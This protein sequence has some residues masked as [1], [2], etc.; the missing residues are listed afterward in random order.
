MNAV[1]RQRLSGR[2]YKHGSRGAPLPWA[3]YQQFLAGLGVGLAVALVVYLSDFRQQPAVEE[4]PAPRP[5]AGAASAAES[6]ADPSAGQYDFCDM[7]PKFEV[8][9]PE[10]ERDVRAD[11]PSAPVARP[12]VYV[13][14]VGSYRSLPEAERVN[15]QLAKQGIE[16]AV[17]RVAVDEDVWHRVRIG[18]ISD[19]AQ[20]NGTR[21]S[22][23]R[24]NFDPIV[25]RVGD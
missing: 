16:A 17:Q 21:D 1:P 19:L 22:L 25:I 3:K 9:V 14:Q 18:P 20:L 23:R 24:A 10:K 6:E 13:L 4:Q 8:V 11:M 7:L 12:G 2:D 15:S 5:A